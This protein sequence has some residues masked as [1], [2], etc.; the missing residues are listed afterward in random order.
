V[1]HFCNAT[2]HLQVDDNL[3]R[4]KGSAKPCCMMD[5]KNKTEL[6][7]QEAVLIAC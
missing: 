5:P 2:I 3:C 4:R 6:N 1:N 7:K